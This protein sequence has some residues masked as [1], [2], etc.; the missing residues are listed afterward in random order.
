MREDLWNILGT[1]YKKPSALV[2]S[3]EDLGEAGVKDRWRFLLY[4]SVMLRTDLLISPS[5]DLES[6]LVTVHTQ[7]FIQKQAP[8]KHSSGDL[9]PSQ[10]TREVGA[11]GAED[12]R[13]TS[14]VL[15]S[16]QVLVFLGERVLG[17]R[18]PPGHPRA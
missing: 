1:I 4:H 8:E 3:E 10:S 11:G 2:A 7:Y 17:V 15:P 12:Y 14:W 6:L 9:E 5:I 18:N 16:G 13:P